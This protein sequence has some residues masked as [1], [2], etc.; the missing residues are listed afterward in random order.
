MALRFMEEHP[1][2]CGLFSE[3]ERGGVTTAFAL[4]IAAWLA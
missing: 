3:A 1:Q 4:I 2:H